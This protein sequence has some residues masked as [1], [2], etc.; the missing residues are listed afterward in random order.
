MDADVLKKLN[1]IEN[2]ILEQNLLKKEVLTSREACIYLNISKSYMY[3][4][5]SGKQIPHFC[6]NGKML[7]FNRQ[8]LDTWLQKN[9][10]ESS[11]EIEKKATDYIL[12]N[13]RR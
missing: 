12:K 11:E 1:E 5:T 10:Q 4:L 2:L 3:K 13:D 6:P 9:H 8:E 7:Y